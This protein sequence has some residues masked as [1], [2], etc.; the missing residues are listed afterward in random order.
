MHCVLFLPMEIKEL[1]PNNALH[2]PPDVSVTALAGSNIDGR[3]E[4]RQLLA[5][6]S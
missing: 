5:P 2:R 4:P 3:Q 6:V 1:T